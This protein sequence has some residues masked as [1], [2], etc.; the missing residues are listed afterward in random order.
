[1]ADGRHFIKKSLIAISLRPFDRLRLNLARWRI[2]A[3]GSRTTVEF[4]NLWKSKMAAIFKK[5][6]KNRDISATVWPLKSL[7]FTNPRRW[8]AAILITVKFPDFCNRLTDF[9]ETRLGDAHL[10]LTVE[11]PLKFL[12]FEN[13]KWRRSPSWK[14]QN[15]D[16]SATVWPIFTKFAMILQNGSLNRCDR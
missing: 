16:I 9:D 1:M 5:N 7:N 8:T 3:P 4:L 2:L 12:I 10:P 13:P 6:H 14:P 11:R 15:R